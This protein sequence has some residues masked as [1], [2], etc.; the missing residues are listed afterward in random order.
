MFDARQ[1]KGPESIPVLAKK[2]IKGHML[3]WSIFIL[4]FITMAAGVLLQYS[5]NHDG[6]SWSETDSI[7]FVALFRPVFC[8]ACAML[9][10]PVF[11]GYFELMRNFLGSF[12]MRVLG[13]LSYGAY[14]C[15]PLAQCLF[16]SMLPDSLVL[17]MDRTPLIYFTDIIACFIFSFITFL[18][19]E[20]PCRRLVSLLF[21]HLGWANKEP[22]KIRKILF[23]ANSHDLLSKTAF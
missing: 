21:G 4:S 1:R 6:D 20:E 3:A 8:L 12:P 9:I 23:T 16:Y 2:G 17:Y 13:R 10:F 5:I 15:F 18:L 11:F 14:V 7:M 22:V 19:L